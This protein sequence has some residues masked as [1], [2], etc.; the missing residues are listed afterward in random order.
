[1][2]LVSKQAPVFSAEAVSNM[3]FTKVN[4]ESYRGK[5]VMLF[6]YPL[7]FTFVCPT[8]IT[9]ISDRVGEFKQRGVE[10]LGVSTDSKFSHLAWEQQPRSEGGLG[11]IEYPLIADFTKQISSDYG[12]LLPGGMALRAT[13]IIDPEGVVQFELVHDLGIGRNV[14]EILRSIDAL[15]YTKKHGEVCPAG[16][17]PG[18]DTIVPDV[19]RSKE[20]FKNNN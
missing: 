13:Y 11:K 16:W 8:E 17:T 7:D 9:A 10:V 6:F 18:K 1:M 19:S 5:W 12:I 20:F 14:D 3:E 2:S 15:Q 4:L